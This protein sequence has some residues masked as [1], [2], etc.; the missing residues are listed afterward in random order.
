[1]CTCVPSFIHL[2]L[3]GGRHL[4]VGP[5]LG[6][7]LT[8]TQASTGGCHS[9]LIRSGGSA[10][11]RGNDSRGKSTLQCL[12][13]TLQTPRIFSIECMYA[14]MNVWAE[15]RSQPALQANSTLEL[16]TL[17]AGRCERCWVG[18]GSWSGPREASSGWAKKG[19]AQQEAF[20]PWSKKTPAIQRAATL[21]DEKVVI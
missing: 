16:L 8:D 5:E 20:H 3:Y 7:G 11:V 1:M 12:R 4:A 21:S 17:V 15:L 14:R 19:R 10:V 6:D 18:I 2:S 9:V 13:S